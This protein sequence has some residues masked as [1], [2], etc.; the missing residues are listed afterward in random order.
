[1]IY[2]AAGTLLM[3]AR[4]SV[5]A[6]GVFRLAFADDESCSISVTEV[7]STTDGLV[8]G[9][10][11]RSPAIFGTSVVEAGESIWTTVLFDLGPPAD[12]L[13]GWR[14]VLDVALTRR[15]RPGRDWVWDDRVFVPAPAAKPVA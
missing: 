8:D 7:W 15:F 2:E 14:V 3:A 13:V 10:T 1:M 4:P 5:R 11:W 6:V 9:A 12:Y